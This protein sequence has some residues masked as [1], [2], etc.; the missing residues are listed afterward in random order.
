MKKLID[1]F[2]ATIGGFGSDLLPP[3]Y[4][5]NKRYRYKINLEQY[6]VGFEILIWCSKNC[7]SK[8]GWYFIPKKNCE[9]FADYENQNAILTFEMKQDAV[10]FML[11]HGPNN[12]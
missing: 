10:Y 11:T 4:G 12:S 2:T 9:D 6:G 8:W 3:G 1:T 7:K 5:Y